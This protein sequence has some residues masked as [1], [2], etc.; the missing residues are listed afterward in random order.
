[1]IN[2]VECQKNKTQQSLPQLKPIRLFFYSS[3]LY[4]RVISILATGKNIQVFF[5]SKHGYIK[6]KYYT[7]FIVRLFL[8]ASIST[9]PLIFL[10]LS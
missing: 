2:I 8:T 6:L 9:L 4:Y 3:P 1:M 5:Y 7:F 10:T